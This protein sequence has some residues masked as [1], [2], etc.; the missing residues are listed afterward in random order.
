MAAHLDMQSNLWTMYM[1]M[2]PF[3]LDSSQ[4]EYEMKLRDIPIYGQHR[5]RA[6]LVTNTMHEESIGQRPLET[7]ALVSFTHTRGG[8]HAAMC[9]LMSRSGQRK[10]QET[11]R[12]SHAQCVVEQDRPSHGSAYPNP[13]GRRGNEAQQIRNA[14]L[15]GIDSR[16]D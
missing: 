9:T 1:S 8:R 10:S 2:D 3:E 13:Y 15:V 7:R 14:F 12:F 5:R 6:K 4:L 11:N 16:T